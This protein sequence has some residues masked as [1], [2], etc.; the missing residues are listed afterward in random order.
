MPLAIDPSVATSGLDAQLFGLA[1]T[2]PPRRFFQKG[3]RSLTW[4]GSDPNGDTLT[5][6]IFYQTFG[7][8][9]WHLLSENLSQSYYTIDGNR[10]PDGSYL[11]KVVASDSPTNP[12]AL[13]LTHESITDAIELDNTPPSIKVM[14]PSVTGQTVEVA[15]DT[16]DTT[17]RVVKGE[18]SVD[19]G[20]WKLIFPTDGIADSARESFKVRVNFTKPGEHVIAFRCADSSSNVG[21]GKMTVKSQ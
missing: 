14:G 2:V 9:E 18:Y 3:A 11:F 4:Q 16:E 8:R 19:G 20:E 12:E 21:T 15:F 17:S 7:D 1:V 10:L 5:F 13:A 6:K